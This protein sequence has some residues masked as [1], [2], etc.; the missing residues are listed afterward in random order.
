ARENSTRHERS[1]QL[2]RPV[3]VRMHAAQVVVLVEEL[4]DR[5]SVLWRC[6]PHPDRVGAPSARSPDLRGSLDVVPLSVSIA[7]RAHGDIRRQAFS[8]GTE[9]QEPQVLAVS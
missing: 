7:A 5:L 4:R 3:E 2:W 6:R 1:Y 9:V 8:L